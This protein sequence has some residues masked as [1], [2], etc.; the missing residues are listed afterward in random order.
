[1]IR[2]VMMMVMFLMVLMT[3]RRRKMWNYVAND[4][5]IQY[6]PALFNLVHS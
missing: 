1:M 6:D 2:R 5:T 3:M 4:I